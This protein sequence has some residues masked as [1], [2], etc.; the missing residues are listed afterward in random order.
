[1]SFIEDSKYKM[2]NTL[3][4]K[5]GMIFIGAS[6]FLN[7]NPDE[8]C[9]DSHFETPVYNR[10]FYS[11]DINNIVEALNNYVYPLEPSKIFINIGENDLKKE[12]FSIDNFASKFE[13]VLLDIHR[14]CPHCKIYTVGLKPLSDNESKVNAQLRQKSVENG[15]TYISL[16]KGI[17]INDFYAIE[18]YING[19]KRNENELDYILGNYSSPL[20]MAH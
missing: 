3:A 19:V 9:R 16:T 7:L 4:Q 11:L 17:L 8:L 5:K 1:M 15:C 12:N 10:S 14:H 6:Y 20:L 13:F 18:K 2:L